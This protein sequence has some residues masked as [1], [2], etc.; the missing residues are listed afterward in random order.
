MSAAENKR[1]VIV[2]IFVLLGLVI[3]VAG[4]FTLGGQQK[5]FVQTVKVKAI[6]NSAEGLKTGN[7]VRFSGVKIG[8]IKDISFYGDSQVEVLMTIEENA[9]QFIHKDARAKIGSES[10]IGNK[11][12]EIVGGSP[13]ARPVEDG[14]VLAAEKTVSSDDIMATLQENNKNLVSIT[15]DFKAISAK[16]AAGQGTVGA[17]INDST[18]ARNFRSTIN[19]LQQAAAT[20]ARAS[21]ALAQFSARLNNKEGLANQLL[22]DTVIFNDLKHSLAQ[23]EKT[24]ESAQGLADNLKKASAKMNDPKNTMGMMLNDEEFATTLKSTLINLEAGTE[25]FDENMEA[26]QENVFLKGYLK[27]KA[28]KGKKKALENP[29][30]PETKAAVPKQPEKQPEFR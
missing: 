5:R 22:T 2:G 24:T 11:N 17:L 20:T 9:R 19:S 15:A 6:F 3:F 27:V 29:A 25:K 26:L 16:V 14:D 7:N 1:S 10:L 8:T 13:E 4:V 23:L 21:G 12:V 28:R 18:M 30:K